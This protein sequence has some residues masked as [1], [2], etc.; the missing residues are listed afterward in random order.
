MNEEKLVD[1]ASPYE[2]DADIVCYFSGYSVKHDS[3]TTKFTYT[4]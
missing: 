2:L 4:P 1:Q 3:Y